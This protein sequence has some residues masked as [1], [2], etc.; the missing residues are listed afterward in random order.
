LLPATFEGAKKPE[1]YIGISALRNRSRYTRFSSSGGGQLDGFT[2]GAPDQYTLK[3]A[4]VEF[5]LKYRGLSIQSENHWKNV[6]DNLRLTNTRMRGSYHEAGY[7]PHQAW[8]R[9]PKEVEFAY[10]YAF[11]DGRVGIPNDLRQE[12]TVGFNYFLE[13]HTNKFSVDASRLLIAR[14]SLNNLADFR[15]RVQWDVHF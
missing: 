14:A 2:V 3:Q 5:L 8:S 12:H 15:Y 9:F 1:A 11:L 6:F 10:R 4:N 13:G 7:F